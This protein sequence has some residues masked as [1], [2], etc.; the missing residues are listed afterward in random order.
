MRCVNSLTHVNRCKSYSNALT[1]WTGEDNMTHT[2][3]PWIV[4]KEY[5]YHRSKYLPVGPPNANE[6]LRCTVATVPVS[7]DNAIDEADARLIA[8]APQLLE[9][10]EIVLVQLGEYK[11]GDGAAKFHAVNIG[12][13]AIARAKG[14]DDRQTV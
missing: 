4:G 2:P 5:E 7:G 3:G 13:A 9:A 10:L 11:D 14:E 8:A 6:C 1:N 12:K